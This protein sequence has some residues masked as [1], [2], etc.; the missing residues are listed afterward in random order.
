MDCTTELLVHPEGSCYLNGPIY[1][2]GRIYS[3]GSFTGGT[4]AFN[5]TL[6]VGGTGTFNGGIATTSISASDVNTNSVVSAAVTAKSGGFLVTNNGGFN[7][8]NGSTFPFKADGSGAVT[9][10]RISSTGTGSF[11]P[12]GASQVA[13]SGAISAASIACTGTGTFGSISTPSM[14][15][16]NIAMPTPAFLRANLVSTGIA[17]SSNVSMSWSTGS[18]SIITV[19]TTLTYKITVPDVG[20]YLFGGKINVA[21]AITSVKVI[22]LQTSTNDGSSY[23]TVMEWKNGSNPVGGDFVLAPYINTTVAA[24]QLFHVKFNNDSGATIT[25]NNSAI[26]SFI[27]ICRI[28]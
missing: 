16:N 7:V 24:N 14:T 20:S 6:T 17:A 26:L 5:G 3:N 2:N 10:A 23:N 11:G 18:S 12:V 15:L 28:A 13:V 19:S 9:C 27:T 21:T 22:A 25:F 1:C 4:G 8:F